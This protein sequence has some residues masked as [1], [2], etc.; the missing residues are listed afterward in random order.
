MKTD[1]CAEARRKAFDEIL[2]IMN[3][4]T[5]YP[6]HDYLIR[7]KLRDEYSARSTD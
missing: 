2:E 6:Y 5:D 1:C 7:K 4:N 3:Q